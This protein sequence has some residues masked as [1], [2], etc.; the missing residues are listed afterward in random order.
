MII[1]DS[2]YGKI[3]FTGAIEKIIQSQPL[4]RLKN[5]HQGGAVFLA[6]PNIST[7]RLEHSL[8]VCYLIGVLGGNRNE[9]IAGL[10]HDISHTAFSH[11]IDYVLENKREDFH[12]KHKLRFLLAPELS[13]ILNSLGLRAEEFVEDDRFSLLETELPM[14]CADRIDYTLRDLIAWGKISQVEA[15]E[16]ISSLRV[17][18]GTI[19][20]NSISWGRWF[21]SNYEYLNQ[22]FFQD[23]KNT[24]V[25]WEFTK[26]LKSALK[27]NVLE[28]ED[29]F[30]DDNWIISKI[31]GCQVL[32]DRLDQIKFQC[33]DIVEHTIYNSHF[34]KRV[35]DPL[36]IENS[37]V[38]PLSKHIALEETV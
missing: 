3:K 7:S 19:A 15:Q 25:N 9:Q 26:L 11:I 20:V 33:K 8:G 16:F 10:L 35:V 1:N 12:E 32:R 34:K 38:L 6:Y 28:I 24:M 36:V 13:R 23:L 21:Q 18:N 30:Q 5:I 17:V 14:L 2:V 22:H 29:F 27:M 4:Q 37:Y 31:D